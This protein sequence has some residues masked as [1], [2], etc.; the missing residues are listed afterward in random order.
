M[1]ADLVLLIPLFLHIYIHICIHICIYICIL[2]PLHGDNRK[3]NVVFC[4]WNLRARTLL[5][6]LA[7]STYFIFLTESD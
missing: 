2:V 4:W 3:K 6:T 5:Y 1:H 7:Q